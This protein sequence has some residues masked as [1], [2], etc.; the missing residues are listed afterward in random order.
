MRR[1]SDA[2]RASRHS[3]RAGK[4]MYHGWEMALTGL[5]SVCRLITRLPGPGEKPA[6]GSLRVKVKRNLGRRASDGREYRQ[7]S[8]L[9]CGIFR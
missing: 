4:S 6:S 9:R 3:H 2:I 8:T 7:G 1:Q 5:V